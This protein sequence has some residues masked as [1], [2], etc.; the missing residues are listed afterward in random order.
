MSQSND[1]DCSTTT[2]KW[3]E[4][5]IWCRKMKTMCHPNCAHLMYH[6]HRICVGFHD[7]EKV[8]KIRTYS[9]IVT[10]RL[11][12]QPLSPLGSDTSIQDLVCVC[13][14]TGVPSGT[15]TS[16]TGGAPSLSV[17]RS[18]PA[19]SMITPCVGATYKE[20]D[21]RRTETQSKPIKI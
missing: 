12:N 1:A 17:E 8:S 6:F 2:E 7:K 21:E 20:I 4:Y 14:E 13:T 5:E 3:E 10:A 18:A 16:R 15:H 19:S 9:T 11:G